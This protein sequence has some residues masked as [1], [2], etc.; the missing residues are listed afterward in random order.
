MNY[1]QLNQQM[2]NHVRMSTTI[3]SSINAYRERPATNINTYSPVNKECELPRNTT[4]KGHR[5]LS[6]LDVL[7]TIEN[8]TEAKRQNKS[9]LAKRN[10]QLCADNIQVEFNSDQ[11]HFG[12]FSIQLLNQVK[13]M[14][15]EDIRQRQ[16][17]IALEGS[18]KVNNHNQILMQKHR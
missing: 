16:K 3:Q 18:L 2:N 14:K 10:S 6:V 13:D 17:L 12:D 8:R 7:E 9:S 1:G 4:S 11:R 15:R 5:T